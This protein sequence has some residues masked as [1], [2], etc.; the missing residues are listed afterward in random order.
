MP[1]PKLKPTDEDRRLVKSLTAVGTPQ[2]EIAR[3]MG[4]R[5]VKTLRK[6]YRRELDLGATEANANVGGAVYKSAMGGN[7]D[8]QKFWLESRAGWKRWPV[9]AKS[10]NPPPFVV[11]REPNKE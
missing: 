9:A 1:R 4:I 10:V 8:A 3:Q 6:Y 7:T 5:S 11:A 2:E